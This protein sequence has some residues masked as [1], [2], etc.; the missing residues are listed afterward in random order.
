MA[1]L[2]LLQWVA[3]PVLINQLIIPLAGMATAVILGLPVVKAIVRFVERKGGGTPD[4]RLREELEELRSRLEAV[5]EVRTRILELEE[6]LDF[7]ER[8]L[9]RSR[10]RPQIAPER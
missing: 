8:M 4:T 7:A 3:D 9:A 1:P 2:A 10:E 6:R 5:E